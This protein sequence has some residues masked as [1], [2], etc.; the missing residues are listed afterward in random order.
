MTL[1]FCYIPP[2]QN[3]YAFTDGKEVLSVQLDGGASRYRKDILN[4]NVNVTVQWTVDRDQYNF[5]RV[6]YKK[7]TESGSLPFMID[8]YLDD[9]YTLTTHVAH[10]VPG[11]FGLKS[12]KGLSFVVGATLEVKPSALSDANIYIADS[13]YPIIME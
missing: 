13:Q 10:F 12:Q 11:T 3:G 7:R 9:P 1:Q 4:A 2:D 6:F 8:L 5:L